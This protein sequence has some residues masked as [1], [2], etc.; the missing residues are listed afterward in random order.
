MCARTC[1]AAGLR[2]Y[3]GSDVDRAVVGERHLEHRRDA[4][5]QRRP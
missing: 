5:D 3:G 2:K 1:D 4:A